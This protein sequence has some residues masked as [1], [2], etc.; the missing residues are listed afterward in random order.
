MIYVRNIRIFV[1][2]IKP[3]AL[4]FSAIYYNNREKC[5]IFAFILD[6]T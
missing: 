2:V 3:V 6:R 4:C 5:F 1:F